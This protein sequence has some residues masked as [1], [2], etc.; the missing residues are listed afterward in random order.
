[1]DLFSEIEKRRAANAEKIAGFGVPATVTPSGSLKV[2][3]KGGTVTIY[4]I[5]Y[6]RRDSE[7]LISALRDQSVRA[8]ADIRERATS[9]KAEFRAGPIR[10]ACELASIEYQPWPRLGSTVELREELQASGDFKTF[11]DRFRQLASEKMESD[12]RKLAQSVNRIP[13]ALLCY[14]RLHEDCHRSVVAE[15]VATYVDAT[16]VAIQ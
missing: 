9:R 14:E 7:G 15:L 8:I 1:M 3:R 13:T 4:T 2:I 12:L 10:S 16:I 11:A 5:G 6:E